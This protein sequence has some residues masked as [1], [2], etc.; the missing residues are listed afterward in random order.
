[1]RVSRRIM[2]ALMWAVFAAACAPGPTGNDSAP[3]QTSP[4]PQAGR[5]ERLDAAADAILASDARLELLGEH[6]GVTEGPLWMDDATGGYL[7]FSDMPANV[8]YK[9]TPAG[10]ISVFLENSGYTGDD[11]LNAGAQSMSGP[12]HVV[13]IG[14]NGVTLDHEGRLVIAAMADRAVARIERDGSRTILADRHEGKRLNGPNDVVVSSKGAI[15]FT[16]MTAGM[17]GREKSPFRELPY[18]GVYLIKNGKLTLLE[19]EP[20]GGMPNG[21]ALSPDERKLYVGS[22]GRILEYD[23]QKDDTIADGRQLIAVGTDGMKVD[24]QGNL[25]TTSEGGVWVISPQGKH[26]ATVRLP[27]IPG[28]R[29]TNLAFG[30][31]DRRTL[32]ITARTHLY[33]LPLKIPGTRPGVAATP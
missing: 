32:Y 11:I 20:G 26:L 27:D 13:L 17:R 25:Y 15:Y 12:V 14:S 9:R 8:I 23:I 21:I 18:T 4:E 2:T 24:T 28:V 33:R 6:F 1:M 5:I 31:T 10:Q 7:L 22:G 29:T 19:K 30:G 16:D 3:G